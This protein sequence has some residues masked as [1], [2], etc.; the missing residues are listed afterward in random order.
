MGLTVKDTGDLR[1]P[2][3]PLGVIDSA[4][5]N[6][7]GRRDSKTRRALGGVWTMGSRGRRNLQSWKPWTSLSCSSVVKSAGPD[8]L[9][10]LRSLRCRSHMAP[11][12]WCSPW[13]IF[14]DISKETIRCRG[15]LASKCSTRT[16][17]ISRQPLSMRLAGDGG[18]FEEGGGDPGN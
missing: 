11:P 6:Q 3:L 5:D 2:H 7:D 18:G 14:C 8:R 15:P 1:R 9:R 12:T 10:P 4:G 13:P 17:L 16:A